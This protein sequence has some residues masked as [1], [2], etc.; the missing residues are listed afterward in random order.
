MSLIKISPNDEADADILMHNFNDLDNK[1]LNNSHNIE[2]TNATLTS[3]ITN[4]NTTITETLSIYQDINTLETSGEIELENNTVNSIIPT[5]EISF[6]LPTIE[7]NT[8][9]NQILIQIKLDNTSYIDV[10]N[11][12]LDTDYY[13]NGIKPVFQY[14]GYY[15]IIYSYDSL[16]QKWCVG[17]IFKEEL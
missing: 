13:F 15:D 6:T 4:V 9:Y 7:D 8:K 3:S 2:V 11:G 1:I 16:K 17:T 10:D 5:D 12:G 14:E